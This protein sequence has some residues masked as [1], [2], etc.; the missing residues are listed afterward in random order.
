MN[1]F[2]DLLSDTNKGSLSQTNIVEVNH[3]SRINNNISPTRNVNF[4]LLGFPNH[5]PPKKTS[6]NS[7]KKC[8]FTTNL[9]SFHVPNSNFTPCHPS[10]SLGWWFGSP[11]IERFINRFS[12]FNGSNP[13]SQKSPNPNPAEGGLVFLPGTH[14]KNYAQIVKSSFKMGVQSVIFPQFFAG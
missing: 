3:Q 14:L 6:Q 13:R 9:P 2:T 4:I 7:K 12:G 10:F 8:L 1:G 5:H 11:K